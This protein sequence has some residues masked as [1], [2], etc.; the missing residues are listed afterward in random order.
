MSPKSLCYSVIAEFLSCSEDTVRKMIANQRQESWRV[1][2][3]VG[4]LA[5]AQTPTISISTTACRPDRDT[6]L[7]GRHRD[8][9]VGYGKPP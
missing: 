2:R 7:S 4:M 5:A 1:S 6:R 8:D 9:E 3:P